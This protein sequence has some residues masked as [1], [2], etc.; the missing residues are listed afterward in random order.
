MHPLHCNLCLNNNIYFCVTN[1]YNFS[2]FVRGVV[3]G[4]EHEH[5]T[6]ERADLFT[7][8]ENQVEQLHEIMVVICD[9]IDDLEES[10]VSE[11]S[12]KLFLEDLKKV[13]DSSKDVL[14]TI[15][16]IRDIKEDQQLEASASS[17]LSGASQEIYMYID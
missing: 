8:I 11:A 5:G 4:F 14:A 3:D 15:A 1:F 13:P 10:Q 6:Q 7:S 12:I 9:F 16:I 17:S 2:L